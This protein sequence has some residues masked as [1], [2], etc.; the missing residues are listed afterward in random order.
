MVFRADD[1]ADL[2]SMDAMALID[3][4]ATSSG[5]NKGLAQ[6]LGL[7]AIGKRPLQTAHG[8]DYVEYY[9][10]RIGVRPDDLPGTAFPY[11]FEDCYGFGLNESEHFNALIGMDILRQCDLHLNRSGE[12]VLTLN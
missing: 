11:V 10:F 8:L 2:T 9:M 1:P 4:G 5:V 6:K 12:C 3:T 7:Q